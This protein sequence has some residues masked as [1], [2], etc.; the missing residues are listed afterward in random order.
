MLT[1]REIRYITSVAECGSYSRAASRLFVSQPAL[2]QAIGRLEKRYGVQIF[3]RGGSSVS[4]TPTGEWFV[5]TGA[6]I[7]EAA[8][9]MDE[10]LSLLNGL[11]GQRIRVGI[12]QF[13]S[14]HHL[15]R[16]LPA[17]R[18]SYAN[19]EVDILEAESAALEEHVLSGE[20][21]IAM[22]PMPVANA[23]LQY[24]ELHREQ[25][26]LAVPPSSPLVSHAAF[27]GDAPYID[28]SLTKNEDYIFL[29]KMRF[30]DLAYELCREAGFQPHII[31]ET[32]NWDTAHAFVRS[33]LGITFIPEILVPPVRHPSDPFYFRI[34]SDRAFRPYVAIYR[35]R[36]ALSDITLRFLESAREMFGTNG[37]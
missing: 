27:A 30:T 20:V 34:D 11:S 8:R 36:R 13:Y 23:S 33:G 10:H 5:R 31:Y 26:F 22:V 25:I 17:F 1:L 29:R 35:D 4:L 32:K 18:R 6:D 14:L 12:S 16:F 24:E 37:I 19:V 15:S 28:L 2:S 3:T 21:D 7:L 9:R